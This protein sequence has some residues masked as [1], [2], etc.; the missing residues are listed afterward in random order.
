M[1]MAVA[2]NPVATSTQNP[3]RGLSLG[4]ASL[5]GG[6][7]LLLGFGLV[8]DTL[9][10]IWNQTFPKTVNEFLSGA[11]LLIAGM[12]ALTA[13]CV[14]WYKLDQ[15]F[16][17]PGLRAGSFVAAATLFIAAWITISIGNSVE[18][19]EGLGM[20]VTILV[21]LIFLAAIAFTFTRDAFDRW[22]MRLEDNGWFTIQ[23][24]K[25]NQGVRVRRATVL[26]LLVIGLSGVYTLV[27]H[28]FFRMPDN[29]WYWRV[30]F[31]SNGEEFLYVP[32]LSMF[33][34]LGP[35]VL[36]GLVIWFS[37][38]LVNWPTFADFLIATEAEI[39]KV[40]WTTRKRLFADTIVVLVT[41]L[42]MTV[43]LFGV[44]I[45]W[46]EVLKGVDVLHVNLK[47]EQAKQQQST[48][49]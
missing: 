30:P 20:F 45:V 4:I 22:L 40:S 25:G 41:V 6:I 9:P 37:I 1:A 32:L 33:N 17:V 36:I 14:A 47:A 13:V 10:W 26:G 27:T 31:S 24:F 39:N 34:V 19:H 28:Q 35:F 46:F 5:A 38:R 18:H 21:G 48:Q 3:T 29:A 42:V 2:E 44:D 43:F 15:K 12:F 49:W 11:L 7:V 8:F 16:A 23:P